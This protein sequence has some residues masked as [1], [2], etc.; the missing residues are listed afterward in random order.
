MTKT[1]FTTLGLEDLELDAPVTDAEVVAS[2]DAMNAVPDETVAVIELDAEVGRIAESGQVILEVADRLET[3]TREAEIHIRENTLT[4]AVVAI[5]ADTARSEL[6]RVD[7][8][9]VTASLE[10]YG[11][12]RLAMESHVGTVKD[13]L[14][15]IYE[16]FR[17]IVIAVKE[18]INSF[19]KTLFS[20]NDRLLKTAEFYHKVSRNMNNSVRRSAPVVASFKPPLDRLVFRG[21]F[22]AEAVHNGLRHTR[23]EMHDIIKSV[24]DSSRATHEAVL[25]LIGDF[26][27]TAEH[28]IRERKMQF[29]ED[30]FLNDYAKPYQ[31]KLML[32]D[33][34]VVEYA[35]GLHRSYRFLQQG[36]ATPVPESI[37]VP[38]MDD[39][40]AILESNI[41]LIKG[42]SE[43][44]RVLSIVEKHQD[45]M[46]HSLQKAISYKADTGVEFPHLREMSTICQRNYAIDVQ[47]LA[48]FFYR[49]AV[50]SNEYC[51]MAIR[52]Y[53]GAVP[54]MS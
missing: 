26:I 38:T 50:A 31:G 10:G 1:V 49:V 34:A 44:E 8:E 25:A 47:R 43:F 13:R 6:S 40:S 17:Q 12:L 36:P 20:A 18:A 4:P 29:D 23:E 46:L 27:A 41:A 15:K 30:T 5:Y 51:R 52:H 24:G 3:F 32:G 42:F 11:S 19:F 16:W 7:A 28:P 48:N 53:P 45:E 14:R 37:P 54:L 33:L 21:K 9:P 39:I 2:A 22:D 35:I